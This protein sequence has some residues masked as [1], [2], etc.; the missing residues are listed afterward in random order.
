MLLAINICAPE[1]E[2]FKFLPNNTV[3]ISINQEE[4]HPLF[5][6]KLDRND[7][8]ILTVRFS[9][10]TKEHEHHGEIL[11]P[12]NKE[13]A[14]QML[15]FI[16]R[17]KS[18]NFIIHCAAGIS[19]SAAVAQFIHEKYGHELKPRFWSVSHPNNFVLGMLREK[20]DY[21]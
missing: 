8:R 2:T 10:V 17:N 13:T 16:E 12:I 3:M 1:A 7:S 11:H 18:K 21:K 6:L 4:P 20:G 5:P 9:D 15:D 19:R 14:L